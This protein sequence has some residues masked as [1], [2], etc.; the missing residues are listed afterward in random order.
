M[1][2]YFFIAVFTVE[3]VLKIIAIG[4]PLYWRDAWNRFDFVVVILSLIG[5]FVNAGV[6]TCRL[7]ERLSVAPRLS[8][9]PARLR[10]R[11]SQRHVPHPA[12]RA[13]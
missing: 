3:A 5:L 6:G 9:P 8:A 2:N 12:P 1:T 11:G 7:P 10:S 4:F 13:R